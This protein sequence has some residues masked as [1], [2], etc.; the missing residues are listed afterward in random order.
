VGANAS[1]VLEELREGLNS[2]YR[3]LRELLTTF[4]LRIEGEGLASA[5]EE[6]VGEFSARGDIPIALDVHLAGCTLSA[7]EE[8]HTLQIVREALSNVLHHA[9]AKRAE[10]RVNCCG[11]GSVTAVIEDDGTGIR[12]MAG[13]HHYG[14]TI[15][16][17]RAK[18][19]GGTLV[20]EQPPTAGTRVTLHFM[21]EQKR[22][23]VI[24][25]QPGLLT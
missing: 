21:P 19:L 16:E 6:T 12:K 4:R 5:L 15:M 20:V 8:I 9:H 23:P 11:D 3:Q 14:M 10:V 18:H 25:I 1:E 7:N 22:N 2:A 24:P 13:V 17:E